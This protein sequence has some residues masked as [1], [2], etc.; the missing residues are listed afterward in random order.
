MSATASRTSKKSAVV[1]V[2][3]AAAVLGIS[4]ASV[5]RRVDDGQ[6]AGFRLGSTRRVL[7]SELER[8]TH[9]EGQAQA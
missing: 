7:R 5:R 6:L 1:S 8:L 9:D 2:R 4:E 3:T